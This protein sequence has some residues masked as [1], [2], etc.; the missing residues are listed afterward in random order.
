[1]N[2]H[3][4]N[5]TIN[6]IRKSPKKIKQPDNQK[7]SKPRHKHHNHHHHHHQKR[8]ALSNS[9]AISTA[10][11]G[12]TSLLQSVISNNEK[13]NG[14]TSTSNYSM[15]TIKQDNNNNKNKKP[16][17]SSASEQ[18]IHRSN[19]VIDK[20]YWKERE[21]NTDEEYKLLKSSNC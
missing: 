2:L 8:D 15:N 11:A 12:A 16:L 10:V 20:R 18:V 4:P 14:R 13:P 7:E 6:E 3:E 19:K 21:S 5:V 17:P 1:M 9:T